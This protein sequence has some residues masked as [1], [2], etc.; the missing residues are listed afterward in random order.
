MAEV[1]VVGTAEVR[2]GDEAGSGG[3]FLDGERSVVE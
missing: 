1:V 3:D 2:M